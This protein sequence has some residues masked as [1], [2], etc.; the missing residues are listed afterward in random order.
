MPEYLFDVLT[1]YDCMQDP[2]TVDW[3]THA[4][5][6][7]P[8]MVPPGRY[9]TPCEIQAVI[10]G[11]PGIRADYV[12]SD[13]VWQVTAFSLTDVLWAVLGISDY[14]GDPEAPHRFSFLAG[15]DEMILLITA[16]LAK[17]CGPFVLLHDSGA[18][19]QVVM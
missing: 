10:E 14:S 12:I 8:A 13:G 16:H 7:L 19:P 15:W 18:P 5:V 2:A 17:R 11:I 6:H 4:A 3:L 9:P 1:L